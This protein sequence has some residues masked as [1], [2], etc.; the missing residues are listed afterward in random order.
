[1]EDAPTLTEQS[2]YV[3]M[4]ASLLATVDLYPYMSMERVQATDR[5]FRAVMVDHGTALGSRMVAHFPRLRRALREALD[6]CQ[7]DCKENPALLDEIRRIR[8]R[9]YAFLG[10]VRQEACFLP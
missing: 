3:S 1:M 5:V 7:D 2:A 6:R 10:G 8:K 4:V 9:H